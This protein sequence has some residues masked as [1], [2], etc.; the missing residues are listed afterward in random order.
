MLVALR[1]RRSL[2][3]VARVTGDL[4]VAQPALLITYLHVAVDS[5]IDYTRNMWPIILQF[6]R[7]RA[8]Y[9]TLP[10]AVIVGFVGYNLENILSDKYTP[11]NKAVQEQ[12]M[13]R[14]TEDDALKDPTNV[15]KLKYQE[16]VL[17]K[18]LSPSLQ[19]GKH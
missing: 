7:S 11:Y 13:D 19:E 4:S 14:L 17:G 18:N 9:V 2:L 5:S 3:T 8:P 12:R 10:F 16:N 15:K 1:D 6:L